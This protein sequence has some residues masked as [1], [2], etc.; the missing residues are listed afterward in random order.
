MYNKEVQFF[1]LQQTCRPFKRRARLHRNNIWLWRTRQTSQ[2]QTET[3]LTRRRQQLWLWGRCRLCEYTRILLLQG[4]GMGVF[5]MWIRSDLALGN[6]ACTYRRILI[7]NFQYRR[8]VAGPGRWRQ[9]NSYWRLFGSSTR[10]KCKW[11]WS[12]SVRAQRF[13]NNCTNIFQNRTTG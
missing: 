7:I 1:L 12:C 4:R 11:G 3:T 6:S 2:I 10:S 9:S 13:S 5:W 8:I